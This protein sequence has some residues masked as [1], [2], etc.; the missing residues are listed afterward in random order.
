[1]LGPVSTD[2]AQGGP[3]EYAEPAK[4]RHARGS[5]CCLR[6]NVLSQRS[7][8]AKRYACNLTTTGQLTQRES[9][10]SC[11]LAA[12]PVTGLPWLHSSCPGSR[13]PPALGSPAG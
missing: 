4:A 7:K 12:W 1:M 2:A 10:T 6:V 5:R 8:H 13:R 3:L 9:L 11:V